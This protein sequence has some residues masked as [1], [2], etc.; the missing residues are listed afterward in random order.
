MPEDHIDVF[1]AALSSIREV[2]SSCCGSILD[3]NHRVVTTRFKETWSRLVAI[4]E[5]GISWTPKV[6]QIS[7]HFSDYFEDPLVEGRALGVK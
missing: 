3:P 5:A 4:P 2:Y 6:H 1:L 7:D